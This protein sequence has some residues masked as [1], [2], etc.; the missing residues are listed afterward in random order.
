MSEV[1][2]FYRATVPSA[3]GDKIT[4]ESGTTDESKMLSQALSRGARLLGSDT[5]TCTVHIT[6][7]K[8]KK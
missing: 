5:S 6:L 3:R 8:Q 7:L 4:F 2:H 1:K